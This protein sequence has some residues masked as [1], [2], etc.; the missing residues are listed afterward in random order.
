MTQV[1]PER[2]AVGAHEPDPVGAMFASRSLAVHYARGVVGA[3][4]LVL[5]LA[6]VHRS[7]AW[8]LLA[9]GSVVAWRGCVSCWTIGL[10]A[11]RAA[12]RDPAAP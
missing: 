6:L 3:V 11:T 9:V 4:L 7:A 5:A 2:P 8:L 10:M 1:Q 12:R